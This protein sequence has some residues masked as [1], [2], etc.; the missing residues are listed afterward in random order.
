MGIDNLINKVLSSLQDSPAWM[1]FFNALL[2]NVALQVSTCEQLLRYHG[3]PNKLD[4]STNGLATL[5][6][7][8]IASTDDSGTTYKIH[9]DISTVDVQAYNCVI[10]NSTSDEFVNTLRVGG[11][12]YVRGVQ[13]SSYIQCKNNYSEV[14]YSDLYS[15]I[16]SLAN[17][18]A[19]SLY[20]LDGGSSIEELTKMKVRLGINNL[21]T[22]YVFE[23]TNGVEDLGSSN[24]T[25]QH[26]LTLYNVDGVLFCDTTLKLSVNDYIIGDSKFQV[27][28]YDKGFL[29]TSPALTVTRTN[30]MTN[31]YSSGG[32]TVASENILTNS[33]E[34]IFQ[35]QDLSIGN[36]VYRTNVSHQESGK[37]LTNK[38][39]VINN[40]QYSG[41][42]LSQIQ[43]LLDNIIPMRVSYS[44]KNEPIIQSDNLKFSENES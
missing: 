2:A 13:S 16:F 19:Y 4:L 6:S 14:D 25:R 5:I 34:Q 28:G 43:S 36:S 7:K 20:F 9:L 1:D 42:L 11:D 3:F 35:A 21:F 37:T 15:F 18:N 8:G 31:A 27:M 26:C 33:G 44:I 12:F 39:Y 30:I 24:L 38:M 10:A 32:T 17:Y 29:V 41:M 23:D 40:N 22:N